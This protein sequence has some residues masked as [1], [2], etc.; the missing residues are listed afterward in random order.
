MSVVVIAILVCFWSSPAAASSSSSLPEIFVSS[1]MSARKASK[2]LAKREKRFPLPRTIVC[3][4]GLGGI[5]SCPPQR[6][7]DLPYYKEYSQLCRQDRN[8]HPIRHLRDRMKTTDIAE[9]RSEFEAV[10]R[11]YGLSNRYV[12]Q[13]K[14]LETEILTREGN[15]AAAQSIYRELMAS[16]IKL[17]KKVDENL[18]SGGTASVASAED[19]WGQAATRLAGMYADQGKFDKAQL[20]LSVF[21]GLFA[22]PYKTYLQRMRAAEVNGPVVSCEKVAKWAKDRA[23]PMDVQDDEYS[24]EYGDEDSGKGIAPRVES[25]IPIDANLFCQRHSKYGGMPSLHFFHQVNEAVRSLKES[26]YLESFRKSKNYPVLLK[27]L[28]IMQGQKVFEDLRD[29]IKKQCVK[30]VQ[31]CSG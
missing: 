22:A 14:I 8:F 24:D 17:R 28:K 31:E 27:R 5:G 7:E 13:F 21:Y 6:S 4:P 26:P 23:W 29:S 25:Q 3:S 11:L 16:L 19:P 30:I 12:D 1:K 2:V 18:K 15:Q 20:T 9:I 10:V